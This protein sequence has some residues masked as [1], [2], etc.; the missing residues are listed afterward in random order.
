M[1][2]GFSDGDI[3]FGVEDLKKFEVVSMDLV[4]L[5]SSGNELKYS[6]AGSLFDDFLKKNDK[7]QN[8]LEAIRLVSGNGY[9]IEIP[10]KTLKSKKIILAYIVNGQ[11]L[12][13]KSKPVRVVIP[14]ERSMYWIKNL[15]KIE[16]IKETANV[17]IKKVHFLE[18]VIE[19]IKKVDYNYY[20]SNDKAIEVQRLFKYLAMEGDFRR[21]SIQAADGMKKNENKNIFTNGYIKV[22]GI[23]VP[24]FLS[25]DIPKGMHVKNLLHFNYDDS[26]IFSLSKGLEGLKK[27]ILDDIEGISMIEIF[28][29]LDLMKAENYRLIAKD[30]NFIEL[31]Y[32]DLKKGILYLDDKGS[33]TS[34]FICLPINTKAKRLMTIEAL[35]H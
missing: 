2:T 1:I 13:K 3:E 16:I 14:E 33:V 10:A 5:N 24:L 35:N 17:A 19:N 11:P 8:S 18:T 26:V 31:T 22:T 20:D 9:S 6:I 15:D 12:D 34:Y 32:D 4:T 28:D 7:S 23:D 27:T 30:G 29:K 25:P 21:V